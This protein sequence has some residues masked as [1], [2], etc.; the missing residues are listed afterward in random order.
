MCCRDEA[1]KNV[2]GLTDKV[3]SAVKH[4]DWEV[5]S[6]NQLGEKLVPETLK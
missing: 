5:H 2:E 1:K 4:F 6:L 3:T